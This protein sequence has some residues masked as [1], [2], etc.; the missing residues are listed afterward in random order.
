MAEESTVGA[1]KGAKRL[2]RGKKRMVNKK[3]II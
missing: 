1:E 3:E 2:E